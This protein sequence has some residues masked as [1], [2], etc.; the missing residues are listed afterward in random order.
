VRWGALASVTSTS[1][2]PGAPGAGALASRALTVVVE[3]RLVARI[4]SRKS[5]ISLNR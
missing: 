2:I 1:T 3:T 4:P 5:S